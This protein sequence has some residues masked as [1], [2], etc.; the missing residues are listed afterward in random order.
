[1]SSKLVLLK[2]HLNLE[3]YELLLFTEHWLCPSKIQILNVNNFTLASHFSRTKHLHGGSVIYVNKSIGFKNRNDILQLGE[4]IHFEICAIEVLNINTVY[5]C[6]YRSPTGNVDIFFDKL[7]QLLHIIHSKGQKAIIL[8]DA[9]I[10]VDMTTNNSMELNNI[11][12][13]HNYINI[14]D[15]PTR[16]QKD[17]S[18]IIDHCYTNMQNTVLINVNQNSISDHFG[19]EVSQVS[20]VINTPISHIT[21]R[22]FLNDVKSNKLCQEVKEEKWNDV[23]E[24]IDTNTKYY[25]FN[26][27]LLECLEKV[28]PVTKCKLK[29]DDKPNYNDNVTYNIQQEIRLYEELL[30][31]KPKDLLY[32]AKLKEAKQKLKQYIEDKIRHENSLIIKQSSNVTKSLW[33]IV[34]KN[35]TKDCNNQSIT[36]LYEKTVK[37]KN[38][39]MVDPKQMSEKFNTHFIQDP[40][41]MI[42][43]IDKNTQMDFSSFPSYHNPTS[44]FLAP[45]CKKEVLSVI[46]HLK[47]SKAYD[48]E[49]ISTHIVKT[50]AEYIA[51]PIAHIYNIAVEEGVFPD[52]LKIAKVIPVLKKGDPFDVGNYRPISI[53][54]IISK[55]F[56]QLTLIRLNCFLEKNEI[57]NS[58]QHGFRKRF[59]TIT[60]AYDFIEKIYTEFDNK[61]PALGIYIDLTNAFGLVNHQILHSKLYNIGIRGK[62]LDFFKSYLSNRKQHVQVNSK[63]GTATSGV[64]NVESGVPQGS[65][66]GPVLYL[67]YVNDFTL[68]INKCHV[69]KFADD[70]SFL[71]QKLKHFDFS[72]SAMEILND[73]K[74][75]FA[76]HKLLMNEAKTNIVHFSN[77]LNDKYT[78]IEVDM[79]KYTLKSTDHTKFLG[80]YLDK[81]LNWSIHINKLCSKLSSSLFALRTVKNK[82]EA[83]SLIQV[84]YAIF[85]SHIRYGI[86]FWGNSSKNNATK[87]LL[88][89]KKAVRVL[90][91]LQYKESCKDHFVN[92]KIMTVISLYIYETLMFVKKN[93][94]LFKQDEI[95]HLYETRNKNTFVR[96]QKHK[97]KIFE[98][99]VTYNGIKLYNLLPNTLKELNYPIFKQKIKLFFV[100]NPLYTMDEFYANLYK[101]S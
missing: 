15:F 98:K 31:N 51:E 50:I 33:Q 93:L 76:S 7:D 35:I 84:Y 58:S 80:F 29:T 66:L 77:N 23:Y 32:T 42:E 49:E 86:I 87:V 72:T 82:L 21:K 71:L 16:V 20:K 75:W 17:S 26:Q 100:N 18:T 44:M 56:E 11:L 88:I 24:S 91:G 64:V 68:C 79:D 55:C 69:T 40:I 39:I 2:S 5:C 70:T 19:L 90:A 97:T 59:S 25:V 53:L 67:I 83:S 38:F 4:E 99:S 45:T 78:T 6:V 57:I 8:G 52:Q 22:K 89:Q 92:L 43:S 27:I 65:I 63:T 95:S 1:M 96:P 47:N 30:C 94:S 41:R 34:Y 54:P 81:E 62:A 9:N 73:V 14:V 85:E 28:I 61:S 74:I 13:S 10:N 12:T 36:G 46:K 37:D 101:L 3:K 60:A 48:V